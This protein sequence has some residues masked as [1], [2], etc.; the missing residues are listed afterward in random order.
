MN[1]TYPGDLKKPYLRAFTLIESMIAAF[2]IAITFMGM[3]ILFVGGKRY[4]LH[5]RSR[6]GGGELG[7]VFLDPLQM[8]VRQDTWDT[9]NNA[10]QL[11]AGG[12]AQ[13][14]CDNDPGHTQQ[15]STP[16]GPCPPANERTL[17]G[18]PYNAEY[19]ISDDRGGGV[20]QN[21]DLRRVELTVRWTEPQP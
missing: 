20:L 18:M 10:L 9:A 21:T 4:M 14:W 7:K 6:M 15:P 16:Q 13:R 17:F 12:T 2:L 1:T 8:Q 3:G 11:P 19:N 5:S